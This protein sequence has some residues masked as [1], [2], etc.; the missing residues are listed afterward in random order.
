MLRKAI[1]ASLVLS[2]ATV[3]TLLVLSMIL[4]SHPRFAPDRTIGSSACVSAVFVKGI[5]ARPGAADAP[6]LCPY[7]AR[8]EAASRCPVLSGRVTVSRCPHLSAR[9]HQPPA[10]VEVGFPKFARV[11]GL[12]ISDSDPS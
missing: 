5:H 4:P 1:E 12:S 7:L 11:E 2:L 10:P 9:G 8:P 3:I 6:G